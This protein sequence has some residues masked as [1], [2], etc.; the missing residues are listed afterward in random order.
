MLS[1]RKGCNCV[2]IPLVLLVCLYTGYKENVF[3]GSC[4]YDF[5]PH[6]QCWEIIGT[7]DGNENCICCLRDNYGYHV[8]SSILYFI[9]QP[10]STFSLSDVT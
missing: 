9:P 7:D 10:C 6:S 2:C 4:T 1:V 3:Y 5:L 8:H